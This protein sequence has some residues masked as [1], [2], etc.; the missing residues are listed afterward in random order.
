MS[1]AHSEVPC[2][3]RGL[4]QDCARSRLQMG[5]M[6]R[7]Q[8]EESPR[9]PRLRHFGTLKVGAR[10]DTRK[11]ALRSRADW[12]AAGLLQRAIGRGEGSHRGRQ[13]D[14]KASSTGGLHCRL[15]RWRAAEHGEWSGWKR[16]TGT[17]QDTA[18]QR[19]GAERRCA[20][21]ELAS[22]NQETGRG[23]EA[24]RGRAEAARWPVDRETET[25]DSASAAV[26]LDRGDAEQV[27]EQAAAWTGKASKGG[28]VREDEDRRETARQSCWNRAGKSRERTGRPRGLRGAERGRS[29]EDV[30]RNRTDPRVGS[31]MQQARSPG[32]GVNRRGREKRRGRNE[33]GRWHDFAEG[34][35]AACCG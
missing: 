10:T 3:P 11:K 22:T 5:T 2:D 17:D 13:N 33:R 16:E 29:Q 19:Q 34:E 6:R 14:E 20:H 31:G 28:G 24:S 32:A 27:T 21:G 8:S 15:A 1:T 26:P 23:T 7:R 9:E 35:A 25:L 18:G 4:E 30:F 12:R